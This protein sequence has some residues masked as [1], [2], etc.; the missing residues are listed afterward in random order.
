MPATGWLAAFAAM[1]AVRGFGIVGAYLSYRLPRNAMEQL[2]N[3][4]NLD[5]LTLD[6]VKW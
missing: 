6:L 4:I 5:D 2:R 3:E 1:A